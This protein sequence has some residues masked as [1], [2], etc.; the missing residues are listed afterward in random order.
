VT[1]PPARTAILLAG[2]LA[3]AARGASAQRPSPGVQPELRLDALVARDPAVQLGAGVGIAA[4]SYVRLSAVAAVGAARV[5]RQGGRRA[6][7]EHAARRSSRATC[8]IPSG[9]SS[10]ACTPGGG[11]GV[12]RDG[13]GDW[14]ELLLL[15]A[16]VEGRPRRGVAPAVELG[17]GGGV[18][19]GVVLRRARAA[20][21]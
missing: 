12:R 2:V 14:D 15:V 3:L 10:A 19:L 1:R 11:L 21:R 9:S 8:S 4:G 18:R 7:G 17:V 6:R 5:R 20:G 16:G 13:G